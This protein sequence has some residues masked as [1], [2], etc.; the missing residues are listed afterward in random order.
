MVKIEHEHPFVPPALEGPGVESAPKESAKTAV[1]LRAATGLYRQYCLVCHGSDGRGQEMR[2]SM[3]VIP[4]FTNPALQ[5][6]VSNPQLAT[7]IL[8]GKGTLMPSFRGRV[9]DEQAQDLVAYVR[10]F[11]PASA[12]TP[13]APTGDFDKRFRELQNQWNELD[14][15]LK[16]LSAPK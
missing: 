16:K 13:V 8:D 12:D 11:R 9:N 3:P 4:D 5:K 10:A 1:R 2:A 7:Y 15:Q 14:K 6:Q